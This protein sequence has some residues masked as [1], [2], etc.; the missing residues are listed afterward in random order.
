MKDIFTISKLIIKKKLKILSDDEKSRLKSFNAEYRFSKSTDFDTIVQK[1]NNY[2]L[3]DKGAAWK[4]ILEKS[5]EKQ[6]IP[7]LSINRSWNKYAIAAS[8]ALLF[9]VSYFF[10]FQKETSVK[11]PIVINTAIE[12]GDSK[13]TLT[14]EDGQRIALEKGTNY[15]NNSVSSNG[16]KII[17]QSKNRAASQIGSNFLTIPRGGQFFIQLADGTKVW[18]N[19]ESQLKYP[20][21][22]VDGKVRK[23]ELI[24][25]EAY[26]EVSPSTAHKG[27]KFEVL[28]K[29]QTVEVIGTQFNVKAYSDENNIYTTLVEGKV[30]INIAGQKHL[31]IP[32][33]QSIFDITNN[34]I[35]IDK[36]DVYSS[37]A[38]KEGFFSFN[39]MS[40]KEIMKV[41]E[42]WYDIK[43]VFKNKAI[44]NR[45]FNGIL[46]KDQKIEEILNI[47][48]N[49]NNIAYEINQKTVIFK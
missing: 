20:V 47:I 36:V 30:A 27:S 42:R 40:L 49:T 8:V 14:L 44:E 9:S 5:R 24:Y 18:L 16:E 1:I 7:V 10:L 13:A 28:T 45:T 43:T 19:S 3:V 32:K 22:F 4:A 37:V 39:S 12:I 17:Y 38:W 46:D 2:S 25:G 23:V 48:S 29:K 33:Q 26:F 6:Q 21:A 11:N 35:K 41:L 34:S 15:K 31:L